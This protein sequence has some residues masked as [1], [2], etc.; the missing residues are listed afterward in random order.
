[1]LDRLRI[2]ERRADLLGAIADRDVGD[3]R[4]KERSTIA[5]L[6]RGLENAEDAW[7]REDA[8]AGLMEANDAHTALPVLQFALTD[9]DDGVRMAAIDALGTLGGDGAAKALTVALEDEDIWLR[10]EA[11][12]AL[13]ANGGTQAIQSLGVAL[14]DDDAAVRKRAVDALGRIS[15]PLSFQLL[16]HAWISERDVAVRAAAEEW[17]QR[18]TRRGQLP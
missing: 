13:E 18:I 5:R 14:Q 10:K 7:D 6:R 2:F 12:E 8:I 17:L 1:M 9:R 16:E 15:S 11:I 4:R 3:E